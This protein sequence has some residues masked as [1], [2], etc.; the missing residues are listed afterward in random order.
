M[1]ITKKSLSRRAVLRGFGAAVAL[2]LLDGMIPAFTPARLT[3]A[4]PRRRLG[5]VYVPNGMNMPQWTPRADG[6][7][8]DFS[9]VLEPLAPYRERMLVLSGLCHKEADAAPGEGGGDHSRGQTAFLTGVHAKK[10]QGDLQAGVSMDQIVAKELGK[11]TQLASIELALE[12]NDMVGA[13]DNGLACAYSA[14]IAWRNETTP[15]PMENNPRAVF[16]RLFGAS[17]STDPRVR[18]SRIQK[19][20]SILDSVSDSV[21]RLEAGIGPRDRVKLGEYLDAVRDIERRLQRAEEQSDQDLPQVS[22]PPGVPASFEEY[23]A[24]MYDLLALAYQADMTRVF[25]FLIGREQSARSYPEIGVPEPHHPISHHQN[26]PE[27]L[28]KLTKV[29]IWHMKLFAKFVEKLRT[30][31]DGDGSL[32]DHSIIVYGSGLSNPDLHDHHDLPIVLLGGGAGQL[33]GGR[34]I[35][36]PEHTPL[37][38]LHLTLLEKMGTPVER[39]GDSTGRLE[40]LSAV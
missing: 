31:P 17:E 28:E 19:D 21:R 2:P 14:T 12:A 13:C 27:L 22:Q 11:E 3:A 6:A 5:I 16:E 23:S 9:P 39:L 36:Y 40:L 34:H 24:I 4:Q 29:N 10:S 7:A 33:K 35:R 26:R 37:T 30:T 38:N 18:M 15:L 8:F 20:R 32:L 25:T 1:I